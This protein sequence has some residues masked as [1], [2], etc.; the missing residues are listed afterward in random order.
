MY[1]GGA[2]TV[3]I[4]PLPQKLCVPVFRR[5]CPYGAVSG[6]G[7][8]VLFPKKNCS[9]LKPFIAWLQHTTGS[10]RLGQ[11]NNIDEVF[12]ISCLPGRPEIDDLHQ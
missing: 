12:L 5:L 1:F 2:V 7:L 8:N 9:K 6:G 10:K 3:G 4:A 11:P